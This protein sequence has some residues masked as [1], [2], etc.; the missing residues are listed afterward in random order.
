VAAALH[1]RVLCDETNTNILTAAGGLNGTKF[2]RV[3][4]NCSPI[5]FS[6]LAQIRFPHRLPNLNAVSARGLSTN[7]TNVATPIVNT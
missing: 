3:Q 6:T 5:L 7:Q 1:G 4:S 2:N